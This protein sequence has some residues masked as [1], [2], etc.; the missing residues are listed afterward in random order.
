MFGG[1]ELTLLLSAKADIRRPNH[2][3]MPHLASLPK[4]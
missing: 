1:A 3:A 4:I 2:A